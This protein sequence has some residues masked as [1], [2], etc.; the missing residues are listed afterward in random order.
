MRTALPPA[1]K[2][3]PTFSTVYEWRLVCQTPDDWDQLAA[4]FQPSKNREEIALHCTLIDDFLPNIRSMFVQQEQLKR[5][6]WD[7]VLPKKIRFRMYLFIYHFRLVQANLYAN[8][9]RSS[10]VVKPSLKHSSRSETASPLS[11]LSGSATPIRR[12]SSANGDAD[13]GKEECEPENVSEFDDSR[14]Y[15]ARRYRQPPKRF[16][17]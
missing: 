10:R 5:K 2:K 11:D 7:P 4:Q 16:T 14:Q 8:I 15:P 13:S 17:L 9:R 1:S 12:Q 6:K 3:R